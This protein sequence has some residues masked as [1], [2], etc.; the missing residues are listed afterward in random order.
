MVSVMLEF[1]I[2]EDLWQ[3][4]RDLRW[5]FRSYHVRELMKKIM[6][7]AS[8]PA[9]SRYNAPSVPRPLERSP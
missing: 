9:A 2:F 5:L 6:C 1:S 3:H 7:T 8:H 4:S